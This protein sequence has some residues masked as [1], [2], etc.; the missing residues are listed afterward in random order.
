MV[1][2]CANPA[3]HKALHYLREGKVFLFSS[4]NPKADSKLPHRL[5]HFWLCGSCA[6]KW[7]LSMDGDNRVTLVEAAKKRFRT[8]HIVPSIAHAS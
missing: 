7:T 2:Y 4:K 8:N 6:K 3:C 1:N 5:E